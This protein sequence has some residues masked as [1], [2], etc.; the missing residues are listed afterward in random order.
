M[1]Q[2]LPTAAVLRRY[3]DERGGPMLPAYELRWEA[4]D[5]HTTERLWELP[6]GVC[7]VGPPPTKFGFKVDRVG[8]DAYAVRLLWDHTRLSWER[9]ARVQLL[10][11]ALAALTGALG[12][13][14]R[15]AL[16]QPVRP[17]RGEM[18]RAA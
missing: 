8:V 5:G 17:P 18:R 14:L 9:L 7:V 6:E 10:A 2:P 4:A 16:E 3:F 1:N 15:A 11:S 12:F 13:D